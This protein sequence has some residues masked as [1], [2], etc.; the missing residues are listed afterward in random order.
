MVAK[1]EQLGPAL[2]RKLLGLLQSDNRDR[3]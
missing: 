1:M 2:S 3:D